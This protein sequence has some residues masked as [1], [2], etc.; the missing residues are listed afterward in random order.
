MANWLSMGIGLG[1]FGWVVVVVDT[2]LKLQY[3]KTLY[4][5]ITQGIFAHMT[6]YTI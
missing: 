3:W 2:M 4:N 5:S 1:I 6:F